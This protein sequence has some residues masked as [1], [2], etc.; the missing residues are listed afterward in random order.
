MILTLQKN[1]LFALGQTIVK[2]KFSISLV[3]D[4]NRRKRNLGEILK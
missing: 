4:K 3:A 2:P 1:V